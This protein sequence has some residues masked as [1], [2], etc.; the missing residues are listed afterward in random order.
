MRQI[1]DLTYSPNDYTEIMTTLWERL[2][3]RGKNWRHVY[4]GLL[5]IDYLIKNGSERVVQECKF[6]MLVIK[7]LS[8][9][10]FIDDEDKDQGISVRQR[11]KAIM[12]L[13][14]DEKRLNSERQTASKNRDKFG[15]AISSDMGYQQSSVYTRGSSNRS[16]GGGYGGGGGGYG[17][18][19]PS[20]GSGPSSSTSSTANTRASTSRSQPEVNTSSDEEEEVQRKPRRAK[21]TRQQQQQPNQ[22]QADLLGFDAFGSQTQQNNNNSNNNDFF[23]PRASSQPQQQQQQQQQNQQ[24]FFAAP[25]QAA[26]APAQQQ[27]MPGNPQRLPNG[28]LLVQGHEI[29]VQQYQQYLAYLQQ[30]TQAQQQPQQ[31]QQHAQPQFQQPP[32]QQQQFQQPPPQQF[33][34]QQSAAAAD[35]WNDFTGSSGRSS[36]SAVLTPSTN[37]MSFSPSASAPTAPAQKDRFDDLLDLSS[38]GTSSTPSG[39]KT[40]EPTLAQLQAQRQ[41]QAQQNNWGNSNQN[42]FF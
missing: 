32:P 24:N 28:N 31:P 39:Q 33:A 1:A 18:G 15:Q 41:T 5:V 38:L 36:S 20:Y 19:G 6:R 26:P 7:T 10:Q 42:S 13:L 23:D 27:T 21:S 34:P 9:F 11:A 8:E 12:E 3:D 4:K 40:S 37:G 22:A 35:D 25:P 16:H 29:T 14:N 17:G 2:E 30:Q